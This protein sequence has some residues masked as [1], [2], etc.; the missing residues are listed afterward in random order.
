MTVQQYLCSKLRLS[1]KIWSKM[2][3]MLKSLLM[4][5]WN[6]Q[7][8]NTSNVKA[9]FLYGLGYVGRALIWSSNG[10][11]P[12][13]LYHDTVTDP[14]GVLK[15]CKCFQKDVVF[16]FNRYTVNSVLSGRSKIDKTKI[17][18]TVGSLMKVNSIAECS[19]WSILQYF[20]PALSD[21]K[22]WKSIF[23]LFWVP[24]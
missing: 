15:W 2:G 9:V 3:N 17:L 10:L 1:Q 5:Y 11:V 22:S 20:W 4:C 8:Y 7:W 21:N 16:C 23:G 24:A 18:M 13:N 6:E 19:P 14:A 12:L